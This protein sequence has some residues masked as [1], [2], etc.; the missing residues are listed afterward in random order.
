LH[1]SNNRWHN[2]IATTQV[3]NLPYDYFSASD[4]A[5]AGGL[6]ENVD[7]QL[8]RTQFFKAMQRALKTVGLAERR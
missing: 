3:R 6:V 8:R 7:L 4:M 5:K 1:L 2:L